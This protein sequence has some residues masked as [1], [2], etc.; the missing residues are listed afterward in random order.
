MRDFKQNR[1]WINPDIEMHA[2]T[3]G[4]DSLIVSRKERHFRLGGLPM[5][6]L[7]LLDNRPRDICWI[8][9]GVF[10][11]TDPESLDLVY[12][13]ICR[14][15]ERGLVYSDWPA[16]RD[17]STEIIIE[18][19]RARPIDFVWR[20]RL[21]PP[22]FVRLGAR[23]LLPLVNTRNMIFGIPFMV[24]LHIWF[25]IGHASL[26]HPGIYISK[27]DGR[28]LAILV[29]VNYAAL[30]L[31]ELG[32]AAGCLRAGVKNGAIG[33]CVYILFPGLYTE[34]TESWKL[35][36]RKR[37]IVD[38]GGIFM[39]LCAGT[40][41]LAIYLVTNNVIAGV[42]VLLCD[43]TCAINLNPF[44]RMD[45][46][47]ILSDLLEMP[48]LMDMNKAVTAALMGRIIFRQKITMPKMPKTFRWSAQI[49]YAYY[50]GFSCMV[51]YLVLI[52]GLFGIPYLVHYYPQLL[53][54]TIHAVATSPGSLYTLKITLGCLMATISIVGLLMV[55]C[56]L[57]M[58][59]ARQI[60]VIRG[61]GTNE[62]AIVGPR[63]EQTI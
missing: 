44:V 50:T 16:R 38:A 36:G 41:A 25:L 5:Q 12:S 11:K 32:H 33:V 18:P 31:H 62:N 57:A 4:T 2:A 43:I 40:V 55:A 34:V 21:L 23:A 3:K 52:T 63:R 35:P 17:G 29:A 45:G 6:V 47:W 24:A 28:N 15:Q 19:K 20:L 30:L 7:N 1:F 53:S 8:A 49:Y 27:L 58:F 14:L 54:A 22:N 60:A 37:L 46:Y 59:F 9:S 26:L 42:M 10:G 13:V 51:L 56:R 48:H 39:S 61:T